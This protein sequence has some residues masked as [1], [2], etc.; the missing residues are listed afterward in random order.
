MS[1]IEGVFRVS[2]AIEGG[3]DPMLFLLRNGRCL[4]FGIDRSLF[5]G[6]YQE[7]PATEDVTITGEISYLAQPDIL[8]PAIRQSRPVQIRVP[9][10]PDEVGAL[11]STDVTFGLESSSQT[12]HLIIQRLNDEAL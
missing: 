8:Q 6:T 1:A 4:G 9:N 2:V 10:P 3:E 7:D 11:L 5:K 12:A